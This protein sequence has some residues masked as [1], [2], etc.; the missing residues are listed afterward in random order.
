MFVSECLA[1]MSFFQRNWQA[2]IV[3][4]RRETF[5]LPSLSSANV[6]SLMNHY[7][8]RRRGRRRRR[9]RRRGCRCRCRC[10]CRCQSGN[11]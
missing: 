5:W 6:A 1:L 8:H 10:R 4:A 9:C 3:K 7:R 11:Q 2:A